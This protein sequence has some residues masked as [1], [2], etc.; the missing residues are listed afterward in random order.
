[1]MTCASVTNASFGGSW[2]L[3]PK[4][5][6]QAKSNRMIPN[7]QSPYLSDLID[8]WAFWSKC[9]IWIED[10]VVCW[11]LKAF[12]LNLET[13]ILIVSLSAYTFR[14]FLNIVYATRSWTS[15]YAVHWSTAEVMLR[16][17]WST[18]TSLSN[19][20]RF[21]KRVSDRPIFAIAGWACLSVSTLEKRAK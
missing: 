16:N 19:V 11:W 14:D 9:L 3:L 20:S 7:R 17:M 10:L 1:M 4:S 15:P 21:W 5:T 18:N 12:W 13:R 8:L 6:F 2:V